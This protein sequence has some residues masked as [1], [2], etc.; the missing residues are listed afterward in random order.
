MRVFLSHSPL[1]AICPIGKSGY[2]PD[3]YGQAK[4]SMYT[5]VA[6][7]MKEMKEKNRQHDIYRVWVEDQS[8]IFDFE[9]FVLLLKFPYVQLMCN[10]FII[11]VLCYRHA[12]GRLKLS[13]FN[14]NQTQQEHYPKRYSRV[15]KEIL[16][17][18]FNH[19]FTCPSHG[20]SERCWKVGWADSRQKTFGEQQ[21]EDMVRNQVYSFIYIGPPHSMPDFH[22]FILSCRILK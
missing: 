6:Y 18:N 17:W 10:C 5:D 7:K 13:A 14:Q 9:N 12:L 4:E 15:V 2:M 22:L 21:W 16:V 8:K 3:C 20:F 1:K 19:L 11:I